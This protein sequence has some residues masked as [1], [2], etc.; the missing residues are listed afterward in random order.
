[1][2]CC[3]SRCRLYRDC[4][5]LICCH[6]VNDQWKLI[7]PVS[8]T[9]VRG[10][11]ILY[12]AATCISPSLILDRCGHW[13]VLTP[14]SI[15][16]RWVELSWYTCKVVFRQLPYMFADSFSVLSIYCVRGLGASSL[17]KF[18]ASR[19][20]P[21]DSTAFLFALAIMRSNCVK[22]VLIV[23]SCRREAPKFCLWLRCA[24][25]MN[26]FSCRCHGICLIV[27]LRICIILDQRRNE[28]G[29]GAAGRTR[30]YLL[31]GGKLA[32]IVI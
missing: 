2:S 32:K 25:Y 15:D 6:I 10:P 9:W 17:Y 31:G 16:A 4:S 26:L 30:R 20:V 3:S 12:R 5:G 7:P 27:W 14:A 21:C 24:M 18:P 8:W 28:G 13:G 23:N 19:D 1:M 11:L 29:A 22:C